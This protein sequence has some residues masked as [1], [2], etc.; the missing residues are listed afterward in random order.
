ML[1]HVNPHTQLTWKDDP[2]ILCVN[3][4][5]EQEIIKYF[6]VSKFLPETRDLLNRSW[7]TWLRKK[8]QTAGGDCRSLGQARGL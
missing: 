2:A 5:N 1:T 8:Y 7:R 3:F 6:D 4:Y